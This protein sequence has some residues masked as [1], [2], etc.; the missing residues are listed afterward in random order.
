MYTRH[1]IK[2]LILLILM[3]VIGLGFLVL[4]N[5]SNNRDPLAGLVSPSVSGNVSASK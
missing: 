4:V 1:F 2:M 5:N 3:A